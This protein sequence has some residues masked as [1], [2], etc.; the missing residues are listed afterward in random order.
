MEVMASGSSCLQLLALLLEEV[1]ATMALGPGHSTNSTSTMHDS[2]LRTTNRSW[3]QPLAGGANSWTV[4]STAWDAASSLD[5]VQLLVVHIL[6]GAHGTTNH[7]GRDR[8]VVV[9]TTSAP[10]DAAEQT[11]PAQVM[12][13]AV[14]SQSPRFLET[15]MELEAEI[16]L[17]AFSLHLLR[18][19]RSI[20]FFKWIDTA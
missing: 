19:G 5:L 8:R 10:P 1:P 3:P 17:P 18:A 13:A 9:W 4:N 6:T 12:A 16:A 11:S 14:V 2:T 7:N 20:S 15:G